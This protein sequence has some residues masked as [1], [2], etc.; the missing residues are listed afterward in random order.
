MNDTIQN[1]Y[2]AL[3][4]EAGAS[5]EEVKQARRDLAKVWH[6]DRFPNDPKMQRKANEKLK[7]I[8]QA[9]AEL[10]AFLAVSEP[11]PQQ[12][13]TNPNKPSPQN[14]ST[15][16]PQ[17]HSTHGSHY[18][19]MTCNQCSG[20]VDFPEESEG[21]TVPCPH[22]H[23]HILLYRSNYNFKSRQTHENIKPKP[24]SK[25]S[26]EDFLKG[27]SP[28]SSSNFTPFDRTTSLTGNQWEDTL[29]GGVLIVCIVFICILL[30]LDIKIQGRLFYVLL[31]G[32]PIYFLPSYIAKRHKLNDY[33]SIFLLNCFTGWSIIGWII[34][35]VWARKDIVEKLKKQ[36]EARSRIIPAWQNILANFI[37]FILILIFAFRAL[38]ILYNYLHREYSSPQPALTAQVDPAQPSTQPIPTQEAKPAPAQ[39]EPKISNPPPQKANYDWNI[40]EIDAS[41]NGNIVVAVN[42]LLRAP[43]IRDL[44]IHPDPNM[45]AATPLKFLGKAVSLTGTVVEIRDY[46]AGSDYAI[47]G[48]ESSSL[49]VKCADGTLALS[50]CLK[51]AGGNV[52]EGEEVLLYGYPVGILEQKN[53]LG[54]KETVLVLV[55][56]DYDNFG[57]STP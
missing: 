41:K 34:A 8:N 10:E 6:P 55:A 28:Y 26:M 36:S 19:K 3:D 33:P 35:L 25:S 51:K 48:K 50:L 12:S 23:K 2:R 9:Y 38:A 54:G 27:F 11:P 37:C 32:F 47:G 17:N 29:V 46:P 31:C 5:L 40:T 52:R 56:N 15:P 21:A 18:L 42:W 49:L 1:C 7:D 22:C 39:G 4:L 57:T 30:S 53:Q 44:T 14:H 13:Q 16:P 24:K 20:V 45:M 43:A